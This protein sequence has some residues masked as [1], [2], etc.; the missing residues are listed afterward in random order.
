MP[1]AI[2][3]MVL[4]VAGA[5]IIAS[6]HTPSFT[7]L[8]HSPFSGLKNSVKTGFC[9]SVANVSGATNCFAAGVI[10]TFT[11]APSFTSKRVRFAAL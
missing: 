5:T 9:E 11:L 3:A 4:A 6:A 2:F 1:L 8:C 7:W 10:T